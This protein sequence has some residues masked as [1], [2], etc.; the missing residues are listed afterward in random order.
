MFVSCKQVLIISVLNKSL[1]ALCHVLNI[2]I[3]QVGST[4]LHHTILKGGGKACW[5]CI[6]KG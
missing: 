6:H 4:V 3:K 2:L 5:G 1:G